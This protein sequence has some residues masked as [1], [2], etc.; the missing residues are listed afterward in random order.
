M[1]KSS[2]EIDL[3]AIR[4]R[5]AGA[6]GPR[7]WRSIEELADTPEFRALVQREFPN[8]AQK[9]DGL[10]RRDFLR[11]MA[12]SLALAGL[13]ACGAP[14]PS[15]IVPYAKGQEGIVPG[16]PL[17]FATALTLGGYAQ[18]VLVESNMGRPTKIEGNPDHPASLG[19]TDAF[20][21]AAILGLYDPDRS[22]TITFEDRISTW[23]AFLGAV[24]P[25]LAAQRDAKGSGIRILTE[26]ITSPTLGS[27]LAALLKTYPNA[28]WHQYEP[29]NRDNAR[30]GALQAF[31]EDVSTVYRFD[32]AD[33][34]L[35]LDADFLGSGPG[36]VRYAHDFSSKRRARRD[37]LA[38]NRLYVLES[39]PSVTGSI[40]DHRLPLKGSQIEAAARELAQQLKVEGI[41]AGTPASGISEAWMAALAK[42]LQQ[43]AGRSIVIPGDAQPP[44]VHALAHAINQSLGNEDKTVVYKVPV[45]V[46]PVSQADSLRE[47]IGDM[48]AGRVDL[49]FV[50]SANPVFSAPIDLQ[51]NA[52]LAKVKL[53][54][55][56]GLYKDETAAQCQWHIPQAHELECWG[57]ARAYDGTTTIQQPLIAPLYSG[58]SSVEMLGMLLSIGDPGHDIVR[59]YWSQQEAGKTDDL[60]RRA[61]RDGV[62]A[63]SGAPTKKVTLRP[64]AL[65]AT[66]AGT[67]GFELQ[68][69]PDPA[70]WDGRFANNG[71]L[72]ELPKPVTQ[73]TWDNAALFSPADAERLGLHNED[74]VNLTLGG[75]TLSAPVWIS[76]GH[77][78]GCVT[79]H[80][81]Y[82]RTQAGRVGNRIGF[83]AFALRTSGAPWRG[84]GL[85][86]AKA[87]HAYPLACTQT[88][89]QVEGRDIVRTATLAEFEQQAKA[90]A[91]EEE[92]P[93][94]LYPA[95]KSEGNAWGMVID[96]T[97]CT[98]CSAC[99][100]ACQA[101]NNSPVV[102]KAEVGRG[103]EMH[104][105][106]IDRYHEG[107]LDNPRVV[108]QPMMC[109]HCEMAPCE[110]VCP[111][112][113][114]VHSAD[115]L[116]MMVYNRCV[117]TRYCSNNCPY[118]VRRF[119]FLDYTNLEPLRRLQYNPD[120]TVRER[121]VME[122]CTYCIQRIST[123]RA[124][125]EMEN[126]AIRDG[127]LV[128]ACQAAC[129]SQAIVFGNLN[130]PSSQVAKLKSQ[131]HGYGVLGELGTLPR[132]SHLMRVRNP[133][134]EIESLTAKGSVS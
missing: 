83:D 10:G 106:R 16:K 45:E 81:G 110:P 93:A 87:G 120:V 34:I 58:K 122:K 124:A 129:P 91:K 75:R 14:A 18:G 7:Y 25:E 29:C 121:G 131:P 20:S 128:T 85:E 76:P 1:N 95:F 52:G 56:H 43:H 47:L 78:R 22:Q 96:Q 86:V 97:V 36:C 2:S 69:R 42:D 23:D 84:V 111:V 19:A 125:A 33:T 6:Q 127:E 103:R 119:N 57:D 26:T 41:R 123:V 8:Q 94:T 113:A 66:A 71:W 39:A 68:F 12:A 11:V 116:N 46:K 54:V 102:G 80:F 117:G 15:T 73:L 72:Q 40:A 109:V 64:L 50:L 132:T 107:G 31:G 104:W 105:L 4:A 112:N 51:F 90:P 9:L 28:K 27:Q 59:D 99:V 115:G 53:R 38:M 92:K 21:Q 3:S 13:T 48:S 60:W 89:H 30:A 44:E 77:A 118:K 114:T 98:G 17:F 32:Q 5:L 108:S 100:L 67:E 70:V 126:R 55:H 101:E 74:L 65:E 49:L 24:R 79:V 130:D 62:V 134:P 133:N 35:S 61:I 88:H 37:Q 63:G 82:G